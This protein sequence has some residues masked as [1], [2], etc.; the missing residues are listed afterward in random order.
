MKKEEHMRVKKMVL[1]KIA[2]KLEKGKKR[3]LSIYSLGGRRQVLAAM[4]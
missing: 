3:D 2:N 4:K 1:T